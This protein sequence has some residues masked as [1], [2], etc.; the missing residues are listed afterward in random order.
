MI[1]SDK[2][3]HGMGK[4]MEPITKAVNKT[5]VLL[6]DKPLIFYFGIKLMP[7]K[8]KDILIVVNKDSK[9]PIFTIGLKLY[10]L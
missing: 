10:E 9:H 1:K 2:F 3:Y 6:H 7:Q 4:R 8:L 5:V